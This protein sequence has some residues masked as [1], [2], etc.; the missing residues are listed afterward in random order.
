MLQ[1]AVSQ[2][3]LS[4]VHDIWKDCTRYYSPSIITLRKFI[5][6]FTRL[7]ALESA[8]AVLECM[9]AVAT[10]ET[11]SLRISCKGPYQSRL[12]IPI[13]SC[14]ELPHKIFGSEGMQCLP[15]IL[16]EGIL[17]T[18]NSSERS[19]MGE[20]NKEKQ[21]LHDEDLLLDRFN[22]DPSY[23]PSTVKNI[24][25][26]EVDRDKINS[27]VL[28]SAA[29]A[30]GNDYRNLEREDFAEMNLQN[31]KKQGLGFGVPEARFSPSVKRILRWSFNNVIHACARTKNYK[32]AEQ[33]FM[34]VT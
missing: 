19:C 2:N 8:Y 11:A 5:L 25:C 34:Q 18:D 4:A 10:R 1:F 9:V 20:F 3:N 28:S 24:I 27:D 17:E 30:S 6:S 23:M 33:L 26:N 12:D 13:P 15:N 29:D 14:S 21:S 16:L 31:K 22:L 7:N 32:L